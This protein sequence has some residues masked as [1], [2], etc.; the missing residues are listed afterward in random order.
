MITFP[1]TYKQQ[2]GTIQ[3]TSWICSDSNWQNGGTPIFSH[4]HSSNMV[5][6]YYLNGFTCSTYYWKW[7]LAIGY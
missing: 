2:V 4:L 6:S 3:I 5:G 7:W 1:I